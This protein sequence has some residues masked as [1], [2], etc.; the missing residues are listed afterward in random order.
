MSF[1]RVY[2]DVMRTAAVTVGH[3]A[4]LAGAAAA[5][6]GCPLGE[7]VQRAGDAIAETAVAQCGRDT[8]RLERC[9]ER[10]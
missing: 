8:P 1:V 6:A 9:G 5:A 2:T 4:A 10:R 7:A 3:G